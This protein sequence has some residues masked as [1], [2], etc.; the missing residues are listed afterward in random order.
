MFFR[1]PMQTPVSPVSPCEPEISSRPKTLR[2][3][4]RAMLTDLAF[5]KNSSPNGSLS[6]GG[7][8]SPGTPRRRRL[9]KTPSPDLKKN[10]AKKKNSVDGKSFDQL[11]F[12]RL[13]SP[14]M[15]ST[16]IFST[17]FDK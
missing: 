11:M 5:R 9:Q 6:L 7:S 14:P 13:W 2:H 1:D 3:E 10:K 16:F 8:G 15:I 4:A 12:V 17:N